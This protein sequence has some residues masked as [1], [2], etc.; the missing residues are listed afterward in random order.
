MR[1]K[2]ARFNAS[3]LNEFSGELL[4]QI[5]DPDTQ[6]EAIN[7]KG[8]YMCRVS[9]SEQQLSGYNFMKVFLPNNQY[10]S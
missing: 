1:T 8:S 3:A 5:Y 6:C 7:G 10:F 4:G 2:S 9:V